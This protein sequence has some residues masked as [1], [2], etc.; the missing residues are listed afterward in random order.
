MCGISNALD[1]TEDDLVSD[2]LPA[3]DPDGEDDDDSDL[4]SDEDV[5]EL[6][7]FEDIDSD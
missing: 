4:D 7:P 3:Y 2:K 1:G 6:D 5:D